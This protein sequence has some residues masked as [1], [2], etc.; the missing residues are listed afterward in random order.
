[1]LDFGSFYEKKERDYGLGW[2]Y[3]YSINFKNVK[4]SI[5][6]SFYLTGTNNEHK[7]A[8][9]NA[10]SS[11]YFLLFMHLHSNTFEDKA[12][13]NQS[14]RQS[15]W[16]PSD[17]ISTHIEQ[18]QASNLIVCSNY[19]GLPNHSAG[20]FAGV[21]GFSPY[22]L[23]VAHLFLT[24]TKCYYYHN[25]RAF[26]TL[27]VFSPCNFYKRNNLHL[28]LKLLPTCTNKKDSPSYHHTGNKTLQKEE[29]W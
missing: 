4:N 25:Y 27:M 3:Q 24:L 11:P 18:Y 14:H 6:N 23:L 16:D 22:L 12:H 8:S 5:N 1:M 9:S 13:K 17:S 19:R 7:D 29:P 21:E 20:R 15:N 26:I 10:H 28:H 2:F